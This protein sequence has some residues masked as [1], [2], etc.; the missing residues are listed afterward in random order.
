MSNTY[1][2]VGTIQVE[3]DAA[4]KPT[5]VLVTPTSDF[6]VKFGKDRFIVL[7]PLNLE[8]AEEKFI[9]AKFRKLENSSFSLL[10]YYS[11]SVLTQVAI[12]RTVVE[13][14]C[15]FATDDSPKVTSLIIPAAS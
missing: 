6:T 9:G 12:K 8:D 5:K 3:L 13:I 1:V 15:E 10:G 2:T 4:G 11:E 7:L 14:Q